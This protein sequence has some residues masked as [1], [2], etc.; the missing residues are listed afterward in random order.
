LILII[1]EMTTMIVKVISERRSRLI[2][3]FSERQIIFEHKTHYT[4]EEESHFIKQDAF[5]FT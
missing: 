4:F 5:N 2:F 3:N 1:Y